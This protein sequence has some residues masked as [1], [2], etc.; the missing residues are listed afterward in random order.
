[1]KLAACPGPARSSP[2]RFWSGGR[3]SPGT[4]R[5]TRQQRSRRI[6][7]LCRRRPAPSRR[8]PTDG[9]ERYPQ[10]RHHARKRRQ[11]VQVLVLRVRDVPARQ[12]GVCIAQRTPDRVLLPPERPQVAHR[13]RERGNDFCNPFWKGDAAPR[14]TPLGL[15]KCG[16]GPS[17]AGSSDGRTK[18]GTRR[19]RA[20]SPHYPY[21]FTRLPGRV[22][23][24]LSRRAWAS[25]C[26][27]SPWSGLPGR[28]SGSGRI[29]PPA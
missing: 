19:R 6:P 12:S 28:S 29:R 3:R 7:L 17:P 16:V 26:R 4:R 15:P 11:P 23:L 24:R 8:A 14:A 27:G 2:A 21:T 10:R 22:A 25:C 13:D 20:V 18:G 1:M 9:S 5:G